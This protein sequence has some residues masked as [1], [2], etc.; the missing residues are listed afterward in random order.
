[1]RK[2]KLFE[3]NKK[4]SDKKGA[5]LI[6]PAERN[7]HAK[8]KLLLQV[9]TELRINHYSKRMEEAITNRGIIIQDDNKKTRISTIK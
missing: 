3:I 7:V 2:I 4:L 9:R 1:L 5:Y 6:I 8:P